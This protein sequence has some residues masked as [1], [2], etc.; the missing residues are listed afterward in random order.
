MRNGMTSFPMTS[1]VER[2]RSVRTCARLTIDWKAGKAVVG[3]VSRA[4]RSEAS[5]IDRTATVGLT[6]FRPGP[7]V[8]TAISFLS[9]GYW[10]PGK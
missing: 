4:S 10:W 1:E 3:N 8:D 6:V 9:L 2:E 7:E 5:M